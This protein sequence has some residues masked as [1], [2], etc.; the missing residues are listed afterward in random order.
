MI[1]V[2]KKTAEALLRD[3]VLKAIVKKATEAGT[4]AYFSNRKVRDKVYLRT[5]LK[6]LRAEIIAALTPIDASTLSAAEEDM[7]QSEP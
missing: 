3:R 1:H 5:Y 2:S 4:A 7:L 6:T